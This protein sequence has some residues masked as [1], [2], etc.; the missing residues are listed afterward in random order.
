MRST[1]PREEAVLPDFSPEGEERNAR[2]K[3]SQDQTNFQKKKDV[4]QRSL[5]RK[6]EKKNSQ[7]LSPTS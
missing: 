7:R 4:N 5:T 6:K 3:S 1:N 2:E